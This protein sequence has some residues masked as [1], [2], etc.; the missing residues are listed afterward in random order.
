METTRLGALRLA[1]LQLRRIRL[2]ENRSANAFN[3][4]A[5]RATQPN[6]FCLDG[7]VEVLVQFLM[8]QL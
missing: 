4:C 2:T 8:N 1:S 3:T 5:P 6:R 7:T